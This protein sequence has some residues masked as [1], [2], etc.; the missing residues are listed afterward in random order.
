MPQLVQKTGFV[1]V[2]TG[3]AGT[4]CALCPQ[5]V[6]KALPVG[7]SEWQATHS[8]IAGGGA[9]FVLASACAPRDEP[10]CIQKAVPALIVPLQRGQVAVAAS[11]CG[12]CTGEPQSGQNFFPVTSCPQDVQVTIKI[13][14]R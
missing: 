5:L 13:P 8:R 7:I 11:T 4:A 9:A 6:Q 14:S 12:A 2:I 3:A 10:Q 1:A